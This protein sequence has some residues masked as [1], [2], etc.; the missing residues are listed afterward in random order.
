MAKLTVPELDPA[1]PRIGYWKAFKAATQGPL[2]EPNPYA[3]AHFTWCTKN[4]DD[5]VATAEGF[6]HHLYPQEVHAFADGKRWLRD[7]LILDCEK[8]ELV[9]VPSE[10]G[11]GWI[12]Y[13]KCNKCPMTAS[14]H[15]AK[16]HT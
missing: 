14:E 1:L 4:Y 13:Y 11:R 9:L 10:H 5:D 15:E 8:H 16:H 7:K 6:C 12:P 3:Q 2:E